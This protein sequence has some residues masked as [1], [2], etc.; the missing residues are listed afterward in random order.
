MFNRK[1]W[2]YTAISRAIT[3]R[4][5]KDVGQIGVDNHEEMPLE[6]INRL[7]CIDIEGEAI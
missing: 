6:W 3:D 5:I 1:E 4:V 2:R 7:Y